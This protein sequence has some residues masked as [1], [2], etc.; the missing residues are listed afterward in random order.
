MPRIPRLGNGSHLAT[1]ATRPGRGLRDT[2][3]SL[4]INQPASQRTLSL[5]VPVATLAP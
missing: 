4:A 1:L 5:S 2:P 3:G